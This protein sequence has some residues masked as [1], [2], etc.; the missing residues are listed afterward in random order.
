MYTIK[1]ERDNGLETYTLKDESAN[2]WIQVVPE[3]GGIITS[4]VVNGNEIFYLNKETLH[5][6]NANIRG[7]NP[8][9]FPISGQLDNGEYEWDGQT[10]SMKNHGVARNRPW[11]VME[12]HSEEGFAMIKLKFSSSEDTKREF[13]FDFE[14]LFTYT[15]KGN[16]L[17]IDQKYHN[18]SSERMPFYA[19]FHPYFRSESKELNI[20]ADAT[21]LLDYND[22]QVKSFSGKVDLDGKKEALALLDEKSRSVSFAANNR[23]I[24]MEYGEE[25]KYIVLWTEK[26]KPFICVEPWMARTGELNRKEE[27]VYIEPGEALN[28]FL[29]IS[30]E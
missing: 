4:F 21:K 3:R 6:S 8:V 18:L 1:Q 29:S 25:F 13:P 23:K 16:K 12:T 7:G 2:S 22:M 28:T 10:Y 14:L 19:G 9:L 17:L 27:L 11:Q 20:E 15:L 24:T 30:V 26:D 5:N